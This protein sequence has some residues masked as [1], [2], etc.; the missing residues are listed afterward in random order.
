MHLKQLR[1]RQFRNYAGLDVVFQ[2]GFYLF[3]GNNGQG[4]S[5]LLE[6]IYLLSTIRSFRGVPNAQMV[7][8]G[9]Q[10]YFVGAT[11]VGARENE[12]RIYWSPRQRQ[13]KL[14]GRNIILVNEFYGTVRAVI[15]CTEDIQLVKGAPAFRRR[16]M[17]FLLAQT[18]PSY[19]STLQRFGRA[20][21]SRN[22]ILKHSF[23]NEAL[24]DSFSQELIL[25]GN[26]ITR[27]RL[28]L[29]Q[30]IAP[31][32]CESYVRIAGE[33]SE[34]VRLV[35][36]PSINGDM[37]VQLAQMRPR[38]LSCHYTL[39]GP[40]RDDLH[41]LMDEMPVAKYGSEGQ[42]RTW[43]LA[44]KMAQTEF[45]AQMHGV[46]PI[47][48]IDDVM[49][50]LDGQ[51]RRSFLPLLNQVATSRGQMFMTCTEKNWPRELGFK[52]TE[53]RIQN[54]QIFWDQA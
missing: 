29:Y 15:F 23:I 1:L 12:I 36:R 53:W 13:I 14:N 46:M 43:A 9:Q 31:I 45:L 28:E 3:T 41:F 33:S 5:N 30:K 37:G 32:I 2:P 38:E 26:E 39:V 20:L 7:R 52:M 40:H 16:Y 10:G 22:A 19:L 27:K 8:N 48:L 35:Y 6:A 51:R 11:V 54:G 50:E 25:T 44:L 17:D 4:K 49:G 24:L 42:K 47:L 18:D 34:K 21:R